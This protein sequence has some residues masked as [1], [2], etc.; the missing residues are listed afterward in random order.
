[1]V[2]I[3]INDRAQYARDNGHDFII[4][5]DHEDGINTNWPAYVSQCNSAQSTYGIPVLPGGEIAVISDAGHCLGYRLKESASSIP[6]NQTLGHQALIDAIN[7]H[8]SPYSY[9]VIAHPYSSSK[10]W[11]NWSVTNFRCLELLSQEY[12]PSSNTISKWFSLLRSNLSSTLS[13][14]NFVVGIGGS[15]CHNFQAP[16]FKG[17]TWV[18]NTS[19][20]ST[21]RATIWD[22]I[23][24]GR[25]SV[26]GRGDFGGFTLNN[27]LQGS[28]IRVSA[29]NTLTFKLGQQP[30]YG[31]K[32]TGI[33]IYDK[34]QNVVKSWLNPG[35]TEIYWS[36]TAP[37][38]D[39][40]YLVKFEF[41][42]SY[43]SEYGE[44][45]TNPIFVDIS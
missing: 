42:N 24:Y 23:R 16:G 43:G 28:V 33:I 12:S 17:M 4:I 37:T 26:F 32:C 38:S 35:S 11:T 29:G 40:F 34:N 27:A 36:T 3:S 30:V 44:V 2:S 7:A 45:W 22:P 6:D 21:N 13:N 31:R 10:P 8:N 19:Y 20:S 18:Y 25:V 14:G 9:A 5:T 1:M 41:T 15:D 39:T